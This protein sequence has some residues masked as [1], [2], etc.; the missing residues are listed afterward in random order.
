[1]DRLK[2][3][4]KK[5][6]ENHAVKQDR[7]AKRTSLEELFNDM[8]DARG[9]IYR[10]NFVRGIFFGAGSAL[11]GTIVIALIVW[12]LSLF[13]NVPLIGDVFKNAQQSIEQTT[14]EATQK[15]EN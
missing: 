8:Y 14:E 5:K 1:M 7:E 15:T 6:R 2:Q 13:V 10:V 4:F 3:F 11:G 9:R 12:I